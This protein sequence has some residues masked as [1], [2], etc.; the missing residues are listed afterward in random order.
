MYDYE[1]FDRY[2]LERDLQRIER[3]YRARGFYRSHVRAGRVFDSGRHKVSIEIVV[4]E[5][6]PTRV[7]R[8][9]VHGL[10]GASAEI[11]E[12]AH[13]EVTSAVD[14]GDRFE[15]ESFDI[16]AQDL[17]RSFADSGHAYVRIKRAADVDVTRDLVSLGFWVEPGPVVHLGQID[18]KGL[19]KIP[20]DQIRRTMQLEPGDLYSLSELQSAERALLDLGVFS[21]VSIKPDLALRSSA[22][23]RDVAGEVGDT[24]DDPGVIQTVPIHVEVQ[25][26]RFHS[27]HLGGG[28][29]VDSQRTDLHLVAG[30]EDRNLFG[31]LRSFLVEFVPGAVLYPTRLPDLEAP[32]RLLPQARLRFEF[33]QPNFLEAITAGVIRA[34]GSISPVLLSS[35][36]DPDAPILG[37]RDLRASAGLERSI[38]W[39]LF[40]SLTHNVQINDPFAY[41]GELDSAMNTAVVSYPELSL[42]LDARDDR[43]EPKKGAYA[44]TTL[45]FAGVGGDA[46]DIRVQPEA[47]VYMP[48]GGRY[49]FAARGS[50]GLLFASNYGD[51]VAANATDAQYAIPEADRPNVVRDIQLMYLRGL[52]AGGPGSNRG[53]ALRDIGP[54]GQVPFYNPGQSTAEQA[55]GCGGAD[56]GPN[57]N[58]PLG[59]FTLWELSVEFRF[60]LLGDLRGALFADAA[61]VSPYDVDFR[62]DRPHLSGGLGFRYATPIGPVRF[63]IGYRIPGLQAPSGEDEY[64][65]GDILGLPIAL[66]FGIGEPF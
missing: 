35:E 52:F 55:A 25:Q 12:D 44:A 30:W 14:I 20:E 38:Y 4:E 57:C 24:Q 42:R 31:G 45:Q 51:T 60:P 61:D 22:R 23:A 1:V 59:G 6:P 46:R 32:E 9:D 66:S 49:N 39:K 15:E 29:Q 37:Y 53:Y 50:F 27:V 19:G 26:S 58:L 11:A 28:L 16:A 56:P 10:D 2:V 33:R 13:S 54:H 41:E 34:Q 65:P 63:D 5:G 7:G 36:R 62:F 48:L 21:A 47:R 8:I 18:I 40:G 64:V 43:L 17:Q 3:Y